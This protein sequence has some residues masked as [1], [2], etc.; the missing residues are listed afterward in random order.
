MLRP[1]TT[2]QTVDFSRLSDFRTLA[3]REEIKEYLDSSIGRIRKI[4]EEVA[5]ALF[6]F[7][8]I[9]GPILVRIGSELEF[10]NIAGEDSFAKRLKQIDKA[11]REGAKEGSSYEALLAKD[12]S[13]MPLTARKEK[14]TAAFR[15]QLLTEGDSRGAQHVWVDAEPAYKLGIAT[16]R[17]FSPDGTH[18]EIDRI[19]IFQHEIVSPPRRPEALPVYLA[20]LGQRIIDKAPDYGL[21]RSEI[22]T[23]IHDM[24]CSSL[25]FHISLVG[26]K[27]GRE[28]NLLERDSFP[29]ERKG[30]RGTDP[31]IPSQLALHIAYA[32]NDFLREHVYLFAPTEDA[33][34]RFS[35]KHFVGTSFIGFRPRKQRFNMG[36]AMFR[37]AGRETFRKEDP[38]G[39]P[40][41]GPL[42]IELRIADVGAIG[43]PNKR[44]YPE[45]FMAPFDVTEALMYILRKGTLA[46]ADSRRLATIEGREITPKT[47]VALYEQY[48]DLPS[49]PGEAA[50]LLRQ[51][52]K[53]EGDKFL[54]PK[55]AEQIIAR[56]ITQQAI[57]TLDKKPNLPRG[58]HHDRTQYLR[59]VP[60]KDV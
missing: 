30:K 16:E 3:L 23:D 35:D 58:Q 2:S 5:E 38:N 51:A 4:E 32:M 25:H 12:D 53:R 19:A 52:S 20:A 31:S 7:G 18:D 57:N 1:T 47:E 10:Y 34:D 48:H 36:S 39:S 26:S 49:T 56:G 33:Y 41:Q 40:D 45:Q 8:V 50:Q 43:H 59:L 15:T 37:G 21:K 44:A 13:F 22:V 55:R 54:G 14:L 46:W 11:S 9:D 42:R 17:G 60:R 27:D 24:S 6:D 29:E 28:I